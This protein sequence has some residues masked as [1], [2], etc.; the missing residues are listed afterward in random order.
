MEQNEL[1]PVPTPAPEAI[2]AVIRMTARATT[3]HWS[4]EDLTLAD[5]IGTANDDRFDL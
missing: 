4:M 3:I 1:Q 5:L 2:E